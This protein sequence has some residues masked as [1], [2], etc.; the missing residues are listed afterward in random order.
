M[1][2]HFSETSGFNGSADSGR[3]SPRPQ[4][5]KHGFAVLLPSRRS[6]RFAQAFQQVTDLVAF[7]PVGPT[8][9]AW[10]KHYRADLQL[11]KP[12][13]AERQGE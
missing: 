6:Q 8:G 1:Y 9:S 7:L 2:R 10:F 11:P 4:G 13:A 3:T 12:I 5:E